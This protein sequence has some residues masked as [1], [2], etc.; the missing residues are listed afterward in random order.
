MKVCE[1]FP[2]NPR[3]TEVS[4]YYIII[5]LYPFFKSLLQSPASSSDSQSLPRNRITIKMAAP[6]ITA[7][8]VYLLP[9]ESSTKASRSIKLPSPEKRCRALTQDSTTKLHTGPQ[10]S[11]AKVVNDNIP[12]ANKSRDE[13]VA[14]ELCKQHKHLQERFTVSKM[15]FIEKTPLTTEAGHHCKAIA[16]RTEIEKASRNQQRLKCVHRF[17]I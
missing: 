15:C 16:R 9:S 10:C 1:H 4:I 3:I 11:R 6:N 12:Q 13:L 8:N 5:T 14:D 2:S 7:T 17:E